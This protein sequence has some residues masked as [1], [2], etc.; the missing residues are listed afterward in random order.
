MLDEIAFL[1]REVSKLTQIVAQILSPGFPPHANQQFIGNSSEPPTGLP[2]TNGFP[3]EQNI[4]NRASDP[5]SHL[6]TIHHSD[7]TS[8]NHCDIQATHVPSHSERPESLHS[9]ENTPYISPNDS[10]G[11]IRPKHFARSTPSQTANRTF[12]VQNRFSSLELPDCTTNDSHDTRPPSNIPPAGKSHTAS[13]T[14][15]R[16]GFY[17]TPQ[18]IENNKSV[19]SQRYDYKSGPPENPRVTIIG[20]STVHRLQKKRFFFFFFYVLN[21]HHITRLKEPLKA[22]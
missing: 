17:I 12:S 21:V 16:N 11:F 22:K 19:P 20:D 5:S 14:K 2:N 1:R 15:S 4:D 18:E 13:V 10:N 3:R 8:S 9:N 6:N 7:Q